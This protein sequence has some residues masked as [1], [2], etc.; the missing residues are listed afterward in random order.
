MNKNFLYALGAIIFFAASAF[1]GYRLYHEIISSEKEVTS[2]F[3]QNNEENG[4]PSEQNP[5]EGRII[6]ESR[7]NS[8][9]D[10]DSDVV[11]NENEEK[12]N[13]DKDEEEAA[14][15]GVMVEVESDDE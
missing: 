6:Q 13:S 9:D 8:S 2:N 1:L 7:N 15:D 5:N 11:S 4:V 14:D 10:S 12:F 3:S